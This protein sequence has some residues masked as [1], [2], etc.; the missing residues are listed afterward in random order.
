MQQPPCVP[1]W[2]NEVSW[3]EFPHNPMFRFRILHTMCSPLLVDFLIYRIEHLQSWEV[4]LNKM[5]MSFQS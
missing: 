5:D 4:V 1:N 3:I 2:A